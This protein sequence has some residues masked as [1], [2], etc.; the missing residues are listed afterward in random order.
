[1]VRTP[2]Q[3]LGFYIVYLFVGLL[4][5]ALVGGVGAIVMGATG[6]S[7]YLIGVK[8]G[9]IFGVAYSQLIGLAI[10]F[11]KNLGYGYFLPSF[12]L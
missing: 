8:W 1:M 4:I 9:A 5:G 7:A 11:S 3:A 10:V 6:T 12:F 2:S